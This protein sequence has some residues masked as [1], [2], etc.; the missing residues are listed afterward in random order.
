MKEVQIPTMQTIRNIIIDKTWNLE[1]G[2]WITVIG[3]QLT[4]RCF[5]VAVSTIGKSVIKASDLPPYAAWLGLWY[6]GEHC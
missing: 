6:G 4:Q 2:T 5:S 1:P 3:V